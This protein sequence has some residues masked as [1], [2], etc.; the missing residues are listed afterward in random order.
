MST[1]Y[2]T[3]GQRYRRETHPL[4]ADVDPDGFVSLQAESLEEALCSAY[5]TFNAYFS[6]ITP[7]ETFDASYY[8][9]GELF[10]V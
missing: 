1:F 5:H 2:V 8:P 6:N 3:F 7:A 10:S 4:F 9:L